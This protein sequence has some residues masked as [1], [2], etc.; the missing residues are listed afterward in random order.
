MD[1]TDQQIIQYLE[2]IQDIY[3]QFMQF[4]FGALLNSVQICTNKLCKKD[5]YQYM[6]KYGLNKQTKENDK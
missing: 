4:F 1:N 3:L 2:E 5:R 6:Q